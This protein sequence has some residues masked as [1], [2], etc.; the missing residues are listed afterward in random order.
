MTMTDTDVAGR[1]PLECSKWGAFIDGVFV[2]VGASP[3]FEVIEPSTVKGSG[4]GR[5]NAPETL[6][7]FVRVESRA[8]PLRSG[9]GSGVAAQVSRGGN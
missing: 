1:G 9:R 3:T 6:H 5:E 7:E 8:I 4:F 2:P